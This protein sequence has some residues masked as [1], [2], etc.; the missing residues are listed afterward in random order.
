M[1]L[2]SDHTTFLNYLAVPVVDLKYRNATWDSYPLYHT[3]YETPFFNE[4]IFDT[5]GFAVRRLKSV[6]GTLGLHNGLKC[7][8]QESI[9]SGTSSNGT[10][11]G[12]TG[13]LL[14]GPAS[15]S[16]ECYN[17]CETH[18]GRVRQ[19]TEEQHRFGAQEVL[20]GGPSGQAAAQPPDKKCTGMELAATI[21]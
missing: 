2:G 16:A 7:T 5:D 20:S 15:D 11:L 21:C 10:V 6:V 3:L 17:V 18:T 13:A 14:R 12:R 8:Q 9:R 4:H 1:P 19:R